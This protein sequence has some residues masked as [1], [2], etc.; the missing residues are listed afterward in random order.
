MVGVVK[1][2]KEKRDETKGGR[3]EQARRNI[4]FK[5]HTQEQFI[6]ACSGRYQFR[7]VIKPPS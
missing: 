4:G 3:E 7:K 6:G 1:G 2:K 5:N